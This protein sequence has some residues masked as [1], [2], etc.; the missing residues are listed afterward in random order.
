MKIEDNPF[1]D[2]AGRYVSWLKQ[3]LYIERTSKDEWVAILSPFL[4]CDNDG[5]TVYAK[6]E[7][8]K[9]TLS[10]DGYILSDL[11]AIHEE[12]PL[13]NIKRHM[14]AV[15]VVES[16]GVTVMD[17][18]MILVTDVANYPHALHMFYRAMMCAS[19][20]SAASFED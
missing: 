14:R 19:D 12:S 17:G 20:L 18:E 2:Y 8:D 7:G 11:Q 3:H 9:I 4:D 1:F 15:H 5:L 10:D 6:K 16:Y 13:K